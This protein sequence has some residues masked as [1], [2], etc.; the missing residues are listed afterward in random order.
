[1]ALLKTERWRW[2]LCV[3]WSVIFK[4]A[5]C[6]STAQTPA[7]QSSNV[8]KS[9]KEMT[10]YS[11]NWIFNSHL[12]IRRGKKNKN[13][14]CLPSRNRPLVVSV[15]NRDGR[16]WHLRRCFLRNGEEITPLKEMEIHLWL[17]YDW[18][19]KW[20]T[21]RQIVLGF[22]NVQ[23][24]SKTWFQLPPRSARSSFLCFYV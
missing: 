13:I 10:D 3:L 14:F 20:S 9:H 19:I 18:L 24:I 2:K 11:S 12:I 17:C 22:G 15:S 6:L 8:S 7:N 16:S 5:V 4:I 1:M 23:K 21:A